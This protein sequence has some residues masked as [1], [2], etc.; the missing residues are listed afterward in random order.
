[1][2]LFFA[3]LTLVAMI[4]LRASSASAVT[5]GDA[6]GAYSVEVRS[7]YGGRMPTFHQRGRSYVLGRRGERYEIVVHN[8]SARRAEVVVSVDG[9]DAITGRRADW[10][11]R[12]YIVPAYG[13]VR[14]DGF[15]TSMRNVA[16]FRFSRVSDSYAALMGDARHV[17]VIGVA[18]FPERRAYVYRRPYY[19]RRPRP[20]Y[21]YGESGPSGGQPTDDLDGLGAERESRSRADAPAASKSRR[22]HASGAMRQA[23]QERPGLGTEYGEQRH[24]PV[25][26]VTFR[27][28]NQ[29]SPQVVLSVRYN[30][31]RGLERLGI[32]THP[33]V[34]RPWWYSDMEKRESATS[35][36]NQPREFAP[37]PPLR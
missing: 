14:I 13:T 7:Q 6:W 29:G 26:E 22:G 33:R 21:R 8:R 34:R 2:R 31:R 28:A 15:R 5:A 9:R 37:P 30:D 10:S 32:N 1:M 25:H 20:Q 27:R 11:A 16:A 12:G 24:S 36:R 19:P 17:G 35:F 3:A 18:V 4:P 23:P